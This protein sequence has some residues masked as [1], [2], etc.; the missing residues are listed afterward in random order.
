MKKRRLPKRKS[1]DM[2]STLRIVDKLFLP[3]QYIDTFVTREHSLNT[4]N[5]V[6]RA[7]EDGIMPVYFCDD[8]FRWADQ[9]G[10]VKNLGDEHWAQF[11]AIAIPHGLSWF[12]AEMNILS[13]DRITDGQFGRVQMGASVLHWNKRRFDFFDTADNKY[14]DAELLVL[15]CWASA[16]KTPITT[17]FPFCL[18]VYVDSETRQVI[19]V[20]KHMVKADLLTKEGLEMSPEEISQ[21][22]DIMYLC[23]LTTIATMSFLAAHNIKTSDS[24]RELTRKERKY[25]ESVRRRLPAYEHKLVDL[26]PQKETRDAACDEPTPRGT[27][28]R[29][30]TVAGHFFTRNGKK[31]WRRGHSRGD[32]RLGVVQKRTR[33]RL[34]G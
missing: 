6:R 18:V 24:K 34:E 4:A 27:K 33:I 5:K 17:L 29:W 16:V 19:E 28:N 31:Y 30:H 8:V 12:E 21:V 25:C 32:K 13:V 10:L 14:S 11:G 7:L 3:H 9:L 15:E 20:E 22:D 2:P 1:T 26:W 23:S